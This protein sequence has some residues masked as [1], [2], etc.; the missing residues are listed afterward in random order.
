MF[1][2]PSNKWKGVITSNNCT[3][4]LFVF[5]CWILDDRRP[6]SDCR[7]N[8]PPT[9]IDPS[10]LRLQSIH[11]AS[12]DSMVRIST[13]YLFARRQIRPPKINASDIVVLLTCPLLWGYTLPPMM[14][15]EGATCSKASCNDENDLPLMMY[16]Y[17]HMYHLKKCNLE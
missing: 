16:V 4:E 9:P 1:S 3:V 6:R 12:S 7:S 2:I 5:N 17:F 11:H 10:T 15:E 13:A 14:M 8:T